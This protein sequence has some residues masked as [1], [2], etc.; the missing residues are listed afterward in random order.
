M[1]LLKIA[2]CDAA[3]WNV[4]LCG[5]GLSWIHT[6]Q[7]ENSKTKTKPKKNYKNFQMLKNLNVLINVDK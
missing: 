4:E 1:F 3:Y 5:C 7:S 6:A 2:E